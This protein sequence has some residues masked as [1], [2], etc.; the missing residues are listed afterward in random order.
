MGFLEA[1]LES[2]VSEGRIG[3]AGSPSSRDLPR[4]V[5]DVFL[6]DLLCLV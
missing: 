3:L 2:R 5:G 4:L 1:G 6:N